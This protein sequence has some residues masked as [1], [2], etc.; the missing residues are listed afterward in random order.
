MHFDILI[1][2]GGL[3]GLS[4]ALRLAE[5][6]LSVGLVQKR[7][8]EQS[9][10]AWAQG[11]IAAA[12]GPEDSPEQHAA[13][14]LDCGAGLC[15]PDTV[16][17][18]TR[19]APGAIAWLEAQGVE[20]TRADN[21]AAP[22]LHLAREGG[23]G[24]RRIVHAADATGRAVMQAL[25]A[26]VAA[27]PR[28]SRL[29]NHIAIDL[30]TTAKLAL[31]G[32]NRC[33]GAYVLDRRDGQVGT[34]SARAIVLAT[35][36]ASKVYRY[37]TNPDTSTG[38]GIAMAWRA[39]CRVANMEFVQF[40]PTCLYHPHAKSLLISEALRGEGGILV[41]P[42]GRRFMP[43][44]DSRAELAPR[45][46]VARAIDFEMKRGGHDCVYLDIS[47]RPAGEILHHFPNIAARLRGF[48][49]DITR[50]R[51]PVVPAA[52]YS[53][54]GI[55]TDLG[56]ATDLAGL[57]AIGECTATG[58]HGANRLASNSLLECVVFAEAA[59]G[60]ILDG[61]VAG[62]P[63][64]LPAWDESR[65]SDPDE[66]VVVAHNWDELRH[67]M[68]DYVGIVRTSKRLT[69]ALH[70][71]RLLQ[72]EIAE[73]YSNF[74]VTNDLIELRNLALVAELTI[75]SAMARHES[76]GLHFNRNYPDRL[77]E[78]H[79]TV[80]T[81]VPGAAAG[82]AQVAVAAASAGN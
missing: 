60:R 48:G 17:L 39:G 79:D 32:P 45:D 7:P 36:G 71:V 15:H 3:G 78:A 35:G 21:G 52:H 19:G 56:G 34:L 62:L 33:V 57:Y 22:P 28:I 74:R 51:I 23:H 6:G 41:L 81:P 27:H 65:V 75:I 82:I 26:R 29:G 5:S 25:A 61:L 20:F 53:C 12:L 64:A 31:P 80:L 68:W 16:E 50:D 72:E 47:H 63:P 37:T 14:T 76:R 2:G 66:L 4:T 67:F 13:D 70:R 40:H 38:D 59:H 24:Q 8:S 58:L 42:D 73:F 9:C 69:R 11:G 18:V 49:I 43:D 1:I 77:P 55:V 54:G 44:H 10:S 46:I 30:V